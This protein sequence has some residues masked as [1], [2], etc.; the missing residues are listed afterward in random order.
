VT[1]IMWCNYTRQQCFWFH[2]YTVS[3]VIT[4]ALQV[5]RVTR[6]K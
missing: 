4:I 3:Q 6:T 2:Y 5:R 1:Q